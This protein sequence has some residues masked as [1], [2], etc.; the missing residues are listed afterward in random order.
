MT[1]DFLHGFLCRFRIISLKDGLS[2]DSNSIFI[3][4]SQPQSTYKIMPLWNIQTT[5][6]NPIAQLS[7]TDFFLFNWVGQKTF[8]T[9]GEFESSKTNAVLFFLSNSKQIP[10]LE[11]FIL[12]C[13]LVSL[14]IFFKKLINCKPKAN[15]KFNC[16]QI[17]I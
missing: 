12:I 14:I 11:I 1:K 15:F 13:L 10:S 16:V 17:F 7:Y 8:S 9:Y 4:T 6:I 2:L 3:C 5:G